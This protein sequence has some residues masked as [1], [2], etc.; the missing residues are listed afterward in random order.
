MDQ[1]PDSAA[2]VDGRPRERPV[3]LAELNLSAERIARELG[4]ADGRCPDPVAR[5]VEPS[6]ARASEMIEPRMLWLP[7]PCAVDRKAGTLTVGD[8]TFDIGTM[9]RAHV[10]RA[11]AVAL[12]V[13]TIGAKLETLARSQLRDGLML[14]GYTLDAIGSSAA[15][16][17]ADVAEADIRRAAEAAGWK[18]TNRLS[19]GYCQWAT[20]EQRKL[21]AL[22]PD[23]PCGIRLTDSALM[24]PI[25]SVSGIVGLG[26]NVK[27]LDYLCSICDVTTCYKRREGP[28]GR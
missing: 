5:V 18:I 28:S 23:R 20:D 25:K 24:V 12:F 16:A 17:V 4:Y 7:T 14:E 22:L 15:E 27:Y 13:A 11:K 9:M 3:G 10:Q 19:P 2:F 8:T 26:P 1:H 21:F 6:L